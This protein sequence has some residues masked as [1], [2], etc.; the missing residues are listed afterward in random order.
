MRK[1]KQEKMQIRYEIVCSLLLLEFCPF[2]SYCKDSSDRYLRKLPCTF[3]GFISFQVSDFSKSKIATFA[4]CCGHCLISRNHFL[5]IIFSESNDNSNL[6]S[7][8]NMRRAAVKYAVG[9]IFCVPVS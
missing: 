7:F 9:S 1:G 8:F 2:L 4:C 5:G 6:Y 3:A